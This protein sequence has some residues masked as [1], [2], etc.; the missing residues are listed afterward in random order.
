MLIR[1]AKR[2]NLFSSGKDETLQMSTATEKSK[3]VFI[4]YLLRTIP[5]DFPFV[6]QKILGKFWETFQKLSKKVFRNFL[7]MFRKN[8]QK[9]LS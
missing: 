2:W 8:L 4:L 7:K 9:S 3:A 5:P 1:G 6:F